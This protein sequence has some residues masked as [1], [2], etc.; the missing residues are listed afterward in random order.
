[1]WKELLKKRLEKEEKGEREFKEAISKLIE[2]FD[3]RVTIILYGSRAYG[4]PMIG[5][6]YDLLIIAEEYPSDN[7]FERI[8]WLQRNLRAKNITLHLVPLTI[9]EVIGSHENSIILEEAL[10][11]GKIVYDGLKLGGL[12]LRSPNK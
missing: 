9:E 10:S 3:G 6:D 1:M 11:K 2:V 5:S 12:K 4:S 8:S 7:I